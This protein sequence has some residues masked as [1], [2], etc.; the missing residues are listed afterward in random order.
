MPARDLKPE[1][2][3]SKIDQLERTESELWRVSLLLLTLVATGL[4]VASWERLR[5]LPQDLEALPIGVVVLFVLFAAHAWNKKREI[6]ELRGFIRGLQER[7]EAPP[8]ERQLDQ[9]FEVI[10]KSQR[11]YRD[12]IDSLDDLVFSLSLE[13][14]I[15][16]ANRCFAGMFEQPFSEL[17]GHRLDEFLDEPNRAAAEKALPRFLERR[18]WSGS[19]RARVKK[20]GAVRYF[21]C[22]LHAIVKDDRIVG[23]SGLARDIT[24]QRESEL[25]FTELFETLQEGIY[26]SSPDGKLLDANPALVR[27]L[28]YDSKEELL[29][30]NVVDLYYDA[31][32]RPV[33]LR[34][35]EQHSTVR[36]REIVMPGQ[37]PLRLI[38]KMMQNPGWT[39]FQPRIRFRNEGDT[40]ERAC[41]D[42]RAQHQDERHREL[43]ID[44]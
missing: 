42:E 1:S 6:S 43:S 4:A 13:G 21:E 2:T 40:R 11:G 20:T 29:G 15:Q 7:A 18:H 34:D 33:L 38:A 35:L 9:L 27:M 36:D 24:H 26:F 25:R 19:V 12:L 8:S 37:E 41:H 3:P 23:V 5:N 39:I 32:Q 16:A 10:T 44:D 31:A 28:G 30:V 22:A 14:E 17:I